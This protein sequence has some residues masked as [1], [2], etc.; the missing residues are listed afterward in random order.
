MAGRRLPTP[1]QGGNVRGL[2]IKRRELHNTLEEAVLALLL[3]VVELELGEELLASW[4]AVRVGVGWGET[5]C[6]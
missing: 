3:E 1:T 5:R 2:P 4:G 6:R